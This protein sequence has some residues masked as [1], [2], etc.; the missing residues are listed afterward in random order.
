MGDGNTSSSRKYNMDTESQPF[1]P[2]AE[3]DKVQG[4]IWYRFKSGFKPSSS[5]WML[6]VGTSIFINALALMSIAAWVTHRPVRSCSASRAEELR[7][8]ERHYI[9]TRFTD[10]TQTAYFQDPGPTTDAAWEE[11]LGGMFIRVTTEE[12]QVTNQTSITLDGDDSHLAW[13]GVYHDLH[14][15]NTLRRWMHRD[16]YHPNLT[17]AELD[18]LQSH[19]S[20]CL[21]VLRQ[22]IQC[23]AD[24]YLMTFR[25]LETEQKPVFSPKVPMRTCVDFDLLQQSLE[26]RSVDPEEI[27]GLQNPLMGTDM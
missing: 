13:L 2:P 23:H 26:P 11:L 6:W 18:K 22:A 24:A 9:P 25:W 16:Y 12:L 1:L 8:L 4:D 15:I 17:A 3:D 20:H 19:T 5:N 10:Y 14:C 7:G 21:D 27:Q